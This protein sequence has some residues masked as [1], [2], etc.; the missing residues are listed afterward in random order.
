MAS[1]KTIGNEVIL[2]QR[3]P[4]GGLWQREHLGNPKGRWLLQE[5]FLNPGA[6]LDPAPPPAQRPLVL[7]PSQWRSL[8][9]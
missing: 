8:H 7:R 9:F 1:T 2:Q 5:A 4:A 6:L 3:L